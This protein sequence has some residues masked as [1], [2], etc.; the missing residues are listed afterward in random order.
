MY[1]LS[2]IATRKQYKYG[3]FLIGGKNTGKSTTIKMIENIYKHLIGSMPADVI[4][5][6][7]KVFAA[8]NGPTPFVSQLEGLG[9]S[10]T[11]ETEDGATLNAAL[12]KSLTGNDR[13][14]TRGLNEAPKIFV[15]TAQI[16]ISTNMLPRFDRHDDAI[17][18]RMIVIPFLIAHERDSKDTRLPENIMSALSPEFPAIVRVFAEY[19]VKLKKEYGGVIPISKESNSY[20]TEVIAEVESDLDKFVNIN[21]AFEKGTMEVIKDVYDKYIAYY[22]FDETSIKRGEGLSRIRFTKYIVKNYKGSIYESTQ[23]VRGGDPQRAFIGM[24]LKT[25]DEIAADEA[26]KQKEV[27]S[28]QVPATTPKAPSVAAPSVPL[29]DDVDPFD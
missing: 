7:G 6:K 14:P 15:N 2:L 9:A 28:P 27:A 12:W 21:I 3:A 5:P 20:K 11:S 17:I 1:Y 22:D 29:K 16:I 8:G 13:I 10:I 24:R 19:Y 4:V 23:R 18:T 25:F 26:A